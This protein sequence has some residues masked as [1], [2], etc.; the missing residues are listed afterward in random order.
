MPLQLALIDILIILSY[1]AATLLIGFWIS[2][3]ASKNIESYFLGG[4]KLPWYYLGISNASGMFDISGTM[5][6]V[7]LLFVYGLTSI[8]IPWLWPVF[9][10]IFLMVFMSIWLSAAGVMTCTEWVSSGFRASVRV[11]MTQMIL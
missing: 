6:L 10:Q 3:R 1:F 4:N 2:R 11:G 5:W 8:Y 9:N 7:Y